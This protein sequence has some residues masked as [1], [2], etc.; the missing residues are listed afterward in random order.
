MCPGEISKQS[1]KGLGCNMNTNLKKFLHRG[2]LFGGFGPIVVGI[3]FVCVSAGTG[4]I[5]LT[6][7]QVLMTIVSSYLLAFVQAG[8]SVFNEI[9]SW[10]VMK[11]LLCHF[12]LLH[13]AYVGC[14]LVNSWIPF[15]IA[16]VGIFTAIFVVAYLVIWITVYISVKNLGR[17]MNRKLS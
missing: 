10:P 14:Y 8:A 7:G 16:V 5:T 2:M 9:D 12:V 6:A 15:K 17:K 1:K 3:V 4:G 11:S 13:A